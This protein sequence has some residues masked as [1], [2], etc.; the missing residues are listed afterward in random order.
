MGSLNNMSYVYF[1]LDPINSC[2][3]IGKSNNVKSR[4]SE[5][6]TGN[7]NELKLLATVSCHDESAAFKFESKLHTSFSNLYLRGEWFKYDGS[8][9]KYISETFKTFS[10]GELRSKKTRESL[11]IP[12]LFEN[13][14]TKFDVNMFPR[15]FFYPDKPAQ[16]MANY[17][18]AQK[19]T[20]PWRTMEFPTGGKQ[21]LIGP[22][23]KLWSDKVNRVFISGKKHQEN[24]DFN[25]F[26]KSKNSEH[27]RLRAFY[28]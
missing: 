5:L 16:I 15:C 27:D 19:L 28:E 14:D 13:Q 8:L 3:K 9:E 7:P 24:L 6:Q 20:V 1:I 2:V 12:T 11:T 26:S 21:M 17:E 25:N 23:G 4:I 10:K 18:D 22:D